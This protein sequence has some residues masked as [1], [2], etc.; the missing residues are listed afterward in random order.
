MAMHSHLSEAALAQRWSISRRSLQRWRHLGIGPSFIRLRRR[1]VY[2]LGEVE[3]F[4]AANRVTMPG[5]PPASG[6]KP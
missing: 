2:T 4:E 6:G 1:I 3:A 5:F